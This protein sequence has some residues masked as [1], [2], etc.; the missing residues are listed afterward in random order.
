MKKLMIIFSAILFL[1]C[2]WCCNRRQYYYEG[3]VFDENNQPLSDVRVK[4]YYTYEWNQCVTDSSGYF[5]MHRS[6]RD[7]LPDLIFEKEGYKSDTVGLVGGRHSGNLFFFFL[8]ERK[9]TLRMI[10]E[11]IPGL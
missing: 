3:Y 6:S 2:K 5:K 9:D 4:E 8:R 1:S 7:F 11:I 10:K